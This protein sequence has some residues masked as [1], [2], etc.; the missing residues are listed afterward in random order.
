MR[1]APRISAGLTSHA[2][3]L[4]LA[5]CS[6]GSA[7]YSPPPSPSPPPA[8]TTPPSVPQGL[9]ATAQS[10]TQIGLS[11]TASTDA[12]TGVAGYRVYRDAN[13]T[14]IATVT[15]T[16]FTDSGLIANTSYSYTVRAFDGATPANES[17][18]SS[19]ASATT[20]AVT[21]PD[22]TP[23]TVPQG[24]TATA[25]SDTQIALTWNASTDSGSGVAGYRVFRNGG[26]TAIATVTTTSYTD[27]NLTASTA[28]TYTVRAFDAATPANVSAASASANATTNAT[29]PVSGLDSR[30][31][32]TTCLAGDAPDSDVSL[33]VQR[34]FAN[35]PNF[36]QPIAMLQEPGNNARWYV[37]Q[38]T[39]QVL[40]FDNTANVSTTRVFIDVSSR[41]NSDPSSSNDERGLL[42]MAF[43]PDYPAD[44]RVYL[45]YTGS[46]TSLGLVDRVSEFR[47]LDSGNTL[48][49]GTEMVLFNVD[50]PAGNHNGGNIM[51]GLTTCFTSASATAAMPTTSSAPLA[52]ASA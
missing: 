10:T 31:S 38:K 4:L 19:S 20:L 35:L 51:F 30:P 40:V 13:T 39:G 34:A 52:M 14:A 47:T 29:P 43:H 46:D 21:T 11:W 23:P 15:T 5:G 42:G 25:Q 1:A 7:D 8:D 37:V 44:P 49:P 17:A 27:G 32:N 2:L 24:L 3:L 45:Y 36:T 6:G 18:A 50:D 28:Y 33:A 48:S 12:G 16:T 26:A 41:L 9:A 22:T